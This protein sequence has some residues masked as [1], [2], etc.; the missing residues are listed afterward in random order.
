MILANQFHQYHEW[1]YIDLVVVDAVQYNIQVNQ[2]VIE[3]YRGEE[4]P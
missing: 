1:W 3:Q 2:H 4:M